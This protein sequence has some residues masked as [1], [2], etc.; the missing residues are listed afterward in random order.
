MLKGTSEQTITL[1]PMLLIAAFAATMGVARAEVGGQ[2]PDLRGQWSGILRSKP[3]IP[4]RLRSIQASPEGKVRRL[5][6]RL[7][8]RPSGRRNLRGSGKA[9]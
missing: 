2:Y 9:A 4:G 6:L 3:G 8:T 5:R 7:N 1:R